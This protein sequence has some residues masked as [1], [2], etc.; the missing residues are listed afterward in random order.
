M[1]KVVRTNWNQH[2]KMSSDRIL[3]QNI[4]KYKHR[5]NIYKMRRF[6]FSVYV[7]GPLCLALAKDAMKTKRCCDHTVNVIEVYLTRNFIF[8]LCNR[9]I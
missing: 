9:C 7:T 3:I 6:C 8:T 5:G 4:V 1:T 2:E